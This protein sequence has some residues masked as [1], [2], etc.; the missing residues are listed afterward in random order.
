L[1]QNKKVASNA[2]YIIERAVHINN[3]RFGYHKI[4]FSCPLLTGEN[5]NFDFKGPANLLI[6]ALSNLIDNAVYWTTSKRDLIG[7]DFKPAIYI[8]T[9]LTTFGKPSIIVADNGDGFALDP[10]FLI[11]PFKTKKE[12]GMGLGLYFADLVMNMLG[13]KLIFP[14]GSDLEIPK[15]YNGACIA[16]VFN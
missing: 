5:Q 3:N 16:L 2:K 10:E 15:V 7:Q 13:G 14:D 6:S 8:G 1:K 4:I 9:D 11:Q 12:G